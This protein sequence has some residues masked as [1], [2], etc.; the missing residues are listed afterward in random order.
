MGRPGGP[1]ARLPSTSACRAPSA[2]HGAG[3]EFGG[4][5]PGV[6]EPCPELHGRAPA[7]AVDGDLNVLPGHLEMPSRAWSCRAAARFAARRVSCDRA[8]AAGRGP[9]LEGRTS[10]GK[11]R[12][13]RSAPADAKRAAVLG[14]PAEEQFTVIEALAAV[15]EET[16]ASPAAVALSWVQNRPGVTSTLI[17]PRIRAHLEASLAALDVRLAPSRRPASTRCPRRP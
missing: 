15:A 1:M 3:A 4:S 8:G 5:T 12:R 17:G 13:G 2:R 10:S 16:G 11:Y 14:R 6:V 9:R 7:I